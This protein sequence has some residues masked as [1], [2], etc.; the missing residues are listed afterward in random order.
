MK[1]AASVTVLAVLVS[2]CGG[3]DATPVPTAGLAPP[4][5]SPAATV[6]SVPVP[7]ARPTLPPS[8]PP[9]FA[10]AALPTLTAVPAATPAATGTAL[11][12]TATNEPVPGPTGPAAATAVP[13]YTLY[14]S[15]A[16]GYSIEYPSEWLQTGADALLQLRSPAADAFVQI[17]YRDIG[18]VAT[19]AQMEQIADRAL[20]AG[21]GNV[22]V[23]GE[24]RTHADGSIGMAF[25]LRQVP[26]WYGNVFVEQRGT[27]AYT[28]LFLV[29]RADR[30]QYAAPLTHMLASYK[31]E[32]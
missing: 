16:G 11:L 26:E 2:G 18:V 4:L 6:L 12:P 5:R 25:Q 3:G 21:F 24:T 29:E 10:P 17:S 1:L 20:R 23:K 28:G 31:I 7:T 32:R 14:R 15:T 30:E 27:V 8:T 19:P 9:T 22:Y 13:G